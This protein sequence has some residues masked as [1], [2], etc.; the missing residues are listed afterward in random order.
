MAVSLAYCVLLGRLKMNTRFRSLTLSLSLAAIGWL[1][2]AHATPLLD[3]GTGTLSSIT[4]GWDGQYTMGQFFTVAAGYNVTLTGLGVFDL[5]S[6]GLNGTHQVGL[7]AAGGALLR[8]TT[9]GPG[10]DVEAS[11]NSGGQWVFNDIAAIT[12]G[13]GQYV[14]GATVDHGDA[15]VYAVSGPGVNVISNVAGVTYDIGAFG[16][17]G[18]SLVRPDYS[19]GNGEDYFGAGMR[20]GSASPVPESGATI[21]LLGFGLIALVGARRRFRR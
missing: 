2:S 19:G 18:T 12:L 10:D 17:G 8:S 1:P 15:I 20:I 7:W 5:N 21:A 9:V 14:V 13:A 16:Y 11:V 4:G 3:L 6:N